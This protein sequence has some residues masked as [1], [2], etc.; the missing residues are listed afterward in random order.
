[1][2]TNQR[3]NY[4]NRNQNNIR[5]GAGGDGNQPRNNFERPHFTPFVQ[6][7]ID[8]NTNYRKFYVND[9]NFYFSVIENEEPGERGFEFKINL[10]KASPNSPEIN[11]AQLETQV[12]GI[13]S[14]DYDATDIRTKPMGDK[15]R[16]TFRVHKKEFATKIY[17]DVWKQNIVFDEHVKA[18]IFP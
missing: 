14:S 11:S 16:C 2:R 10:F 3:D 6:E 12:L 15:I 5:G 18:V 13:L 1:M 17:V 9:K 8:Q 7:E 4:N